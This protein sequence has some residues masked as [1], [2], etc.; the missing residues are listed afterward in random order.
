MAREKSVSHETT[1]KDARPAIRAE[2]SMVGRASLPV[3]RSRGQGTDSEGDS[4][5]QTKLRR[6][7]EAAQVQPAH[8]GHGAAVAE[9]RPQVFQPSVVR[10][11]RGFRLDDH[12]ILRPP[13]GGDLEHQSGLV[14]GQSRDSTQE[15]TMAP[16]TTIS[17]SILRLPNDLIGAVRGSQPRPDAFIIAENIETIKEIL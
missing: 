12:E 8:R 17:L 6:R 2:I 16:S 15:S 9:V 4:A 13:T 3:R 7:E 11:Q 5:R 1:G 10:D 14:P